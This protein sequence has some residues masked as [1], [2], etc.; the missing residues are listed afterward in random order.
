MSQMRYGD[1]FRAG[2]GTPLK[3]ESGVWTYEQLPVLYFVFRPTAHILL[4][5]RRIHDNTIA[6]FYDTVE[7]EDFEKF[8]QVA[9]SKTNLCVSHLF[10]VNRASEYHVFDTYD[11]RVRVSYTSSSY[12]RYEIMEDLLTKKATIQEYIEKVKNI[13]KCRPPAERDP[14]FQ[15]RDNQGVALGE[16]Q[17]FMLE[18]CKPEYEDDDDD[19]Y[20]REPD[21]LD[22]FGGPCHAVISGSVEIGADFGF[23]VVGG[24][25]YLTHDGWYVCISPEESCPGVTVSAEIPP[26]ERRIHIHYTADGNILMSGWNSDTYVFCEWVKSSCGVVYVTASDD[27]ILRGGPMKLAVIRGQGSE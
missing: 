6:E 21:Y 8:A 19:N 12:I 4:P 1:I 25:T 26:K 10:V 18:I 11:P 23:E 20:E 15:L 2:F 24:I 5:E 13:E 7:E 22:V 9:K 3:E 16:D 27:A 17:T 14:N